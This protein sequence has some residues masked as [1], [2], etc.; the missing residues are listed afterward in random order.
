M[1]TQTPTNCKNCVDSGVLYEFEKRILGIIS[2]IELPS[3]DATERF[4]KKCLSD[5]KENL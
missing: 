5:K 1:W 2:V 4:C 3:A